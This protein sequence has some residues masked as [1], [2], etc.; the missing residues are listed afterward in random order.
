MA[1][2]IYGARTMS[3]IDEALE[4]IQVEELEKPPRCIRAYRFAVT[5]DAGIIAYFVRESDALRFRL[6]EV[7]RLLNP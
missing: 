4:R 3:S 7:N 1:P 2:D 6:A 5:D